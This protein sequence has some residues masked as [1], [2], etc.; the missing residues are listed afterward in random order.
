[1]RIGIDLGG[2]KTE[3]I[4]L[5][6]TGAARLRFRR[7]TP[8]GDYAATINMIADMV[9]QAEGESGETANIGIGTP[10]AISPRTGR[11]KNCN[12]TCLND[13]PLQQD[14]ELA[15]RRPVRLSNDANCFAL[16][17]AIDGAAAR[18]PVVFGV[19]LG[20]GVGGGIVVN[21]QLLEGMNSIAGEWGH[22]PLP[23]ANREE[24]PGPPCY[25]G[26]KGCIETWLSGPAMRR[27]HIACGGQD[28]TA[29]EITRMA[30][31]GDAAC[32]LTL[33]R[34][35][36]RLARALAGVINILDP[37]AIVLGG[38]LSNIS[39]LYEQVPR[40]WSS[41]IFSDSVSTRLLPPAHGDS[42]GVRG[43]AW[44]W[45]R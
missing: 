14:L 18:S 38:G 19:I 24:R 39:L 26:R 37:D 7:P 29:A 30:T 1:M 35:C 28:I 41:Y 13:Q 8:A 22:N 20:T 34:Y 21:G 44:L 16:S 43:A 11:M 10:G 6:K 42:S 2:T 32:M 4:A 25:C 5:D 9:A 40:L 12:S 33:E 31:E 45:G 17:E 15:L 27:D 36:E 23:S 3:L